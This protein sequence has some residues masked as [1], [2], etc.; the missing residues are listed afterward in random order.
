MQS[1]H[2]LYGTNDTIIPF[3]RRVVKTAP[4]FLP[5]ESVKI[6]RCLRKILLFFVCGLLF[7]R[8]AKKTAEILKKLFDNREYIPYNTNCVIAR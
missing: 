7:L 5:S 6:A 1:I 2:F 4:W 8:L 3:C